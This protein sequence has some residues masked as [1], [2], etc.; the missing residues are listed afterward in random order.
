MTVHIYRKYELAEAVMDINSPLFALDTFIHHYAESTTRISSK[1]LLELISD[2]DIKQIIGMVKL[3][4]EAMK[5]CIELGVH[6]LNG[7]TYSGNKDSI[8][9]QLKR[10]TERIEALEKMLMGE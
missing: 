4:S 3:D 1:I 9:K 5:L 7:T 2:K 8:E 10:N 6:P